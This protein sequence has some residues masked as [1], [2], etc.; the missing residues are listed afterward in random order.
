MPKSVSFFSF[1]KNR[2]HEMSISVG[3]KK[4]RKEKSHIAMV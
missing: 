2:K 1:S 3:G 4:K